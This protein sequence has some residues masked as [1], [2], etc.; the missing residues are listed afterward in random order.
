MQNKVVGIILFILALGF[1]IYLWTQLEY[2]EEEVE[3]GYSVAA[4]LNP[5]LAAE[6]YVRSLGHQAESSYQLEMSDDVANDATL[7][8]SNANHVL[9]ERRADSLIEWM[10]KGGHVIIAAQVLTEGDEDVFLSRFGVEKYSN[11]T[12]DDFV[13]EDDNE[14]EDDNKSN[15]KEQESLGDRLREANR[16]LQQEQEKRLAREKAEKEGKLNTVADQL[17]YEESQFNASDLA[18]LEFD[19]VEG[20]VQILIDRE[21]YLYH[22]SF[23]WDDD[24]E[25]EGYK[26]FYWEGNDNGIIFM[27]FD[28]GDGLL[29]VIGDGSIW[30]NERIGLFDHALL[31]QILTDGNELVVFLRGADV[32]S[33]FELIWQ[34]YFELCIVLA[35]LLCLWL[36]Y[37]GR[38]FGPIL[39]T[40]DRGRRSYREHLSAVGDFYWRHKQREDLLNH[41]RDAIWRDFNKK[42]F[43]ARGAG[44][45]EMFERM[46]LLTGK[47][48][49]YIR[50]MM[51][52]EA[53]QDE[54]KFTQ[55][56][57][58]LQQIRKQL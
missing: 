52:G 14:S 33:L 47:S 7:F 28:V 43:S 12:E 22:D 21:E 34:N 3:K 24:T 19:G 37:R 13:D 15:G 5:Y 4:Y 26:P 40:T 36:I 1:G 56:I 57:Q 27:Q 30:D 55:L 49:E 16:Q 51:R 45:T 41:A 8:I 17:R 50:N 23:Y 20:K 42:Y 18:T 58:T 25:Y 31:L 54:F 2:Y 10:Q 48:A 53:P 44:E 39:D 11:E 38:R 9:D 6:Q 35:I 46:A 29:T 32:P